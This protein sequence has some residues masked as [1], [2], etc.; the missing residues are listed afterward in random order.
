MEQVENGGTLASAGDVKPTQPSSQPV[1]T[2]V[3]QPQPSQPK[4]APTSVA[5]KT[6]PTQPAPTT[7]VPK[8]EPPN[9]TPKAA[10]P[11]AV[12]CTW[13]KIVTEMVLTLKS[14]Y[15]GDDDGFVVRRIVK[16]D[17]SCLFTSLGYVLEGHSREK[18]LRLRKVV[19]DAIKADPIEV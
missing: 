3:V 19:A 4:Q 9:A 8:A 18:G 12:E 1:P 6:Q 5:P 15:F 14:A 13:L 16:A 7:S 2:P 10:A 17:N 11:Q